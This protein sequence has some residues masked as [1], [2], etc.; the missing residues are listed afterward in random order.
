M[1]SLLTI[2]IILLAIPMMAQP[3]SEIVPSATEE[4][5]PEVL[6]VCGPIHQAIFGLGPKKLDG[7]LD[8]D[9]VWAKEFVPGF[10]SALIPAPEVVKTLF[11]DHPPKYVELQDFRGI[12]QAASL[13]WEVPSDDRSAKWDAVLDYLIVAN[14][15]PTTGDDVQNEWRDDFTHILM[16]WTEDEDVMYVS[17]SCL[18]S[19]E[20]FSEAFDVAEMPDEDSDP[21]IGGF[22]NR[23][24]PDPWKR[25]T[26]PPETGPHLE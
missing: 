15:L 21:T 8:R 7:Q 13:F 4:T 26:C 24:A 1:K 6:G 9:L 18:P 10:A 19:D 17:Y 25:V 12:V 22:Q 23:T 5:L 2:L 11:A 16:S 3:E 20:E 14:G